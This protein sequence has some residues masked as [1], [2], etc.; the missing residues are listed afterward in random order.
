MDTS[1][2]YFLKRNFTEIQ[3]FYYGKGREEKLDLLKL[4]LKV[5]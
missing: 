3:L 1:E 5:H 2:N 4:M